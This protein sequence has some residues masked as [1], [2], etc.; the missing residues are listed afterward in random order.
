MIEEW[1]S[2]WIWEDE[3]G[4]ENDRGWLWEEMREKKKKQFGL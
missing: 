1:R 2:G 3:I 4:D